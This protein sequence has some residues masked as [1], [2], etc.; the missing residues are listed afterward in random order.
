MCWESSAIHLRSGC[1]HALTF[2]NI[3]T[4]ENGTI[5]GKLP[6]LAEVNNQAMYD[7]F[8]NSGFLRW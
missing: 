1:I 6:C 7:D 2:S 5:W 8:V 4:D 3:P